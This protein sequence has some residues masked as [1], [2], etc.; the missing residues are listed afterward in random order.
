MNEETEAQKFR[1][2]LP[3]APGLINRRVGI[4][5]QGC[6]AP[7]PS[8]LEIFFNLLLS[9]PWKKKE[10][11]QILKNLNL[12]LK[13]NKDC[14]ELSPVKSRNSSAGSVQMKTSFSKQCRLLGSPPLRLAWLGLALLS[15]DIASCSG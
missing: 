11:T 4:Q 14:K 2:L 1:R 5:T 8:S 7:K 3:E 6:L 13:E 12:K 10:D 15:G 9:I